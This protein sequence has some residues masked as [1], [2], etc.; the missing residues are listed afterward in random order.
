MSTRS[1]AGQGARADERRPR[2][3][4]K[5][6]D[7]RTDQTIIKSLDRA[8]VTLRKLAEME[9]AS[10]S[11]LA[12]ALGQSPAT[13][14][15][16]LTTL[17]AHEMVESDPA[18]Q[19]W[20]I[21]PGAFLVGSVFLRR[22]N[23]VERSRPIMRRLMEATGETANLG[24]ARGDHVLFIGQV[25]THD[26]LRAFFPPGSMSPLH[27]SGVGKALMA[28]QDEDR[29]ER[30]LARGPLEAF[31]PKTLTDR[32]AL[33]ADLRETRRRGYAVDDEE[34]NEGMRCVAAPVFDALGEA[35]AGLSVSGPAIRVGADDVA[36]IAAHVRAA[37][38]ELSAK[39]GA[40]GD[41]Q[42]PG[43]TGEG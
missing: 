11:A 14:Y 39:L 3:R 17:E 40:A 35:V 9:A 33:I 16:I 1:E 25:E 20:H 12:E 31:T 38:A 43:G 13:V 41:R 21:G 19:T 23:L 32:A 36:R 30:L 24:V 10:L 7:D 15:R 2:G 5:A 26:N 42:R 27:A 37:A 28:E 22:T 18:A 34:R 4:P 6:F 29:L 8:L